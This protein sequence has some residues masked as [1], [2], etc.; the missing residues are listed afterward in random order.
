MEW[1]INDGLKARA[2]GQKREKDENEVRTKAQSYER[3]G[4]Q[5]Y[6]MNK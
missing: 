6:P 5:Y 3:Q 1:G 4:G 2:Y